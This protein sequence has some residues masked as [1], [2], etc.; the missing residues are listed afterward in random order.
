MSKVKAIIMPY[1][2]ESFG[3]PLFLSCMLIFGGNK[4]PVI[5][6]LSSDVS[7]KD[8]IFHQSHLHQ[9]QSVSASA[10]TLNLKKYLCIPMKRNGNLNLNAYICGVDLSGPFP[11]FNDCD[12]GSIW[13][14]I[15]SA[16]PSLPDCIVKHL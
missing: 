16:R 1:R 7:Q 3:R 6:N 11:D 9:T 2:A 13:P 8:H 15:K 12:I 5:I 4:C 10:K 14:S